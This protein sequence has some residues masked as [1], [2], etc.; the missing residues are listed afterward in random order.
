MVGTA[1]VAQGVAVGFGKVVGT[2][3]L[4]APGTGMAKVVVV[5]SVHELIA[6]VETGIAMIVVVPKFVRSVLDPLA[7]N[8]AAA[9][10][11]TVAEYQ[12]LQPCIDFLGVHLV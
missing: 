9:D 5:E 11:L 6:Q 7:S 3:Q 12:M 1:L 4:V 2:D 8:I 10:P